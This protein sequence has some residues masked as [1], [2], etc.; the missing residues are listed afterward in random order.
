[1]DLKEL[2]RAYFG[3]DSTATYRAPARINLIGEHLDYNGGLVLPAAISLYIS[4]TISVRNDS[5]IKV[6]SLNTK[7]GFEIDLKEIRKDSKYAWANY[8]FGVFSILLDEGYKIPNGLNILIDS[9]IPLGSGLSSSAALLDLI[10]YLTSETFSLD[11]SLEKI[12]KLAQRVENDYLGLKSGIM[13]EAAIALGKKNHCLLLNCQEYE[14]EQIP[15]DLGDYTFVVLK[16]NVP[17]SLVSSKYNERVEECQKGLELIRKKMNVNNLCEISVLELERFKDLISDEIIYQRVKHVISERH[18]VHLFVEAL[19]KKEIVSLGKIL[20]ESHLSL[21]D[22]Y[23]VSG[24]YL[25][26]IQ[27]AAIHAGAIGAR[28]TGAGFGGCAIA[29]IKKDSFTKFREE[30]LNEYSNLTELHADVLE[31]DIVDGPTKCLLH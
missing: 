13:D 11:I 23:E 5:K 3:C 15:L 18:R 21:K 22:D 9:E 4:A 30:V 1:M 16:T 31:V 2:F 10:V 8:V 14:Y 25:D 26:A 24:P 27:I 29:L 7:T 20:N 17:R 19:K 12:A 28:M 6:Y